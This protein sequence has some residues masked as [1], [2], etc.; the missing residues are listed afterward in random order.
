MSQGMRRRIHPR[1]RMRHRVDEMIGDQMIM[2]ES[3]KIMQAEEAREEE[4]T[5]PE[6]IRNPGVE[7]IIIRRWRIVC[8]Y[9]RAFLIIIVAYHSRIRLGLILTV[10]A[11][12]AGNDSQ[13]ELSGQ[14]LKGSQGV[15]L[16]HWQFMSVS[17]PRH[18]ILKFA[19]DNGRR[20]VIRNPPVLRRDADR[21]QHILGLCLGAGCS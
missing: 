13:T 11:R 4:S 12:A 1:H 21:G 20:R 15:V 18:C 10:L 5:P 2:M 7:I 9:R 6:R 17:G 16:P 8:D 19:D 14:V 3:V